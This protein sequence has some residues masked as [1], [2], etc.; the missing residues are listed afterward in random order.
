V[1]DFF[2]LFIIFKIINIEK[3]YFGQNFSINQFI[4]NFI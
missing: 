3:F 2:F 4:E 1:L